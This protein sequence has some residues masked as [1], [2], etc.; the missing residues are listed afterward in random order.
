MRHLLTAVV[1][2]SPTLVVLGAE[3]FAAIQ[4]T[5]RTTQDGLETGGILLGHQHRDGQLSVSRAG[6]PG[7]EAIRGSDAF[8]RDPAHAQRL[9]DAAWSRDRSIWVGDWHTHPRGPAS[10]SQLDLSTYLALLS[11]P[12]LGFSLFLALV[13]VPAGPASPVLFPWVITR[14]D[15]RS[16]SLMVESR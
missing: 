6:D 12:E 11:D 15:V 3:A 2:G 9:A 1:G 8:R 7:P 5:C 13:V 4:E 10:P 16:A 14:T